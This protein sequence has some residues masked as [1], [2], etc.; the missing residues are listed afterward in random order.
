M[1]TTQCDA[2]LIHKH[3]AFVNKARRGHVPVSLQRCTHLHGLALNS[4]LQGI[5]QMNCMDWVSNSLQDNL[6][7][8]PHDSFDRLLISNVIPQDVPDCFTVLLGRF[9]DARLFLM[10]LVPDSFC[11]CQG[12]WR[13]FAVQQR[14]DAQRS[15]FVVTV[16]KIEC[17]LLN[18]CSE[19]QVIW[20][21]LR[22]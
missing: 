16:D 2:H 13:H 15:R 6:I 22:C 20:D 4:A 11:H 12:V 17:C 5:I 9:A 1:N 14:F 3:D 10:M 21:D 19:R 7:H 8:G 18:S